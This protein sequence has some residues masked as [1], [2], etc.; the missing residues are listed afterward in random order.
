MGLDKLKI[1]NIIE[2]PQQKD[3]VHMAVA[4][5]VAAEPLQPGAHVGMNKDGRVSR[6]A[7]HIGVVDPFLRKGPKVGDRF[8]LFLYPGSIKSLRHEWEHPSFSTEEGVS[9]ETKAK[10]QK[11]LE[12]F[13]SNS[14]CPD[15]DTV[16]NAA[17]G[18]HALNDGHD[19]YIYTKNDGEYLYFGGSDA[20]GEIPPEFWVHLEIVSGQ[21]IHHRDRA[22]YFTCSC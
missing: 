14:D 3:A 15:Y 10:S 2:Q 22:K 20:H 19:G 9:E 12:H 1:G 11:W 8:W 7:T 16:I 13:I 17:L 5:V 4:P 18:N 21:K 6:N